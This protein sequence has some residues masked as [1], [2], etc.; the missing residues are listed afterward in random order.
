MNILQAEFKDLKQ[1]DRAGAD[2]QGIGL[3]HVT[4][5]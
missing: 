3:Y 2:D 1:P 4:S 5:L